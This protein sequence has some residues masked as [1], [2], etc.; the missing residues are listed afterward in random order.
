MYYKNTFTAT[1]NSV[2]RYNF[3]QKKIAIFLGFFFML[4]PFEAYQ[5]TIDRNQKDSQLGYW[6]VTNLK[7]KKLILSNIWIPNLLYSNDRD[8]LPIPTTKHKDNKSTMLNLA[9]S[10]INPQ[11]LYLLNTFHIIREFLTLILKDSNSLFVIQNSKEKM[12]LSA[13]RKLIK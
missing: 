2:A 8:N 11:K 7:N 13:Y 4:R 3:L 5:A 1:K 10:I 12:T 9:E 6:L